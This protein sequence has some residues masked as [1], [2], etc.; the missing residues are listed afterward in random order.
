MRTIFID[1]VTNDIVL[2]ISIAL[3]SVIT[4]VGGVGGGGLLIPLYMLVGKFPLEISI[5]L[6]IFTIFGDTLVR[7]FFLYNRKNPLNNQRDLINFEPLLIISLFDANSSFFG[8]ILSSWTPNLMTISCLLAILSITLYKSSTKAYTTYQLEQHSKGNNEI[9]VVIDG[10]SEYFQLKEDDDIQTNTTFTNNN[11]SNLESILDILE[12]QILLQNETEEEQYNCGWFDEEYQNTEIINDEEKYIIDNI[13]SYID[14]A[15][16]FKIDNDFKNNC[17]IIKIGDTRNNKFFNTFLLFG[18]LALISIFSLTR[19]YFSVCSYQYWLQIFGQFATTSILG[20]YT[21]NYI[22]TSY[23]NKKNRNYMFV[24]GDIQWTT[25][26]VK[27]FVL[28]GSLTGFVSTYIGIGGG[29]LTTPIMIQSGMLPEIVV[30]T[31][32]MSTLCSCIISCINYL[33]IGQLPVLYGML[34]AFCSAIGSIA[35]IYLSDCILR[36]YKKQSP[37]VFC[38]ALIIFLSMVLLTLNGVNNNLFEDKE[39]KNICE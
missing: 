11:E 17:K 25:D 12:E 13:E 4:T 5:P 1:D 23:E 37:I 15:S 6:T 36:V 8:V 35:G 26:I 33:L 2:M 29:M 10:I 28:I 19:V 30:A 9:L 22:I 27:R 34:F 16:V 31:S 7:V 39:F 14:N 3:I 38:I 20:Y 21:L 32:S 24:D 18:N